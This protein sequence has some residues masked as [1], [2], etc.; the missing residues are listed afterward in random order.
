MNHQ[1]F[2]LL[3]QEISDQ[4]NLLSWALADKNG[5]GMLKLMLN[6]AEVPEKYKQIFYDI[7]K[8]ALCLDCGANI[9]LITDIILFMNGKSVC[10]EPNK[11]ALNILHKKYDANPNVKIE[12]L[13]V[14]NKNGTAELSLYGQYDRGANIC[15]FHG[16][17]EKPKIISYTVDTLKMSDYINNLSKNVY[18]LK[19]D[20]EG[21]EF[22]VI[23][24]L[25]QSGA[26]HKCQHILCET[27]AR[28][29]ADGDEKLKNLQ[30]IISENKI[31]NIYMEWI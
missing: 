13:A 6:H 16:E 1:D 24:D 14:S 8:D 15:D 3:L 30:Q 10:F 17:P 28:F 11:T 23:P 4:N 7:P 9:G 20:V 5:V 31:S 2:T 19:L 29:F 22:D 26:I 21:S 12:P 18:L 25:I 27:H